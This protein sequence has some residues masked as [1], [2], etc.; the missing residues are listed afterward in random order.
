MAKPT[1]AAGSLFPLA[2]VCA[3]AERLRTFEG[4]LEALPSKPNL[5][6]VLV[7]PAEPTQQDP[8]KIPLSKVTSLPV[9][10]ASRSTLVESNHL[11]LLPPGRKISI[12][13]GTLRVE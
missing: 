5:A 1:Q 8:R 10:V 4:I 6:L 7:Q 9:S 12:R 2:A 3:P 13:S 11:Y